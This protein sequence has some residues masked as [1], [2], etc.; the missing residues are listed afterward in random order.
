MRHTWAPPAGF[1]SYKGNTKGIQGA[2]RKN[3]RKKAWI[4]WN[5][6]FCLNIKT[7]TDGARTFLLPGVNGHPENEEKRDS[8]PPGSPRLLGESTQFISFPTVYYILLFH[9]YIVCIPFAF[10]LHSYLDFYLYFICIF[11]CMSVAF[12]LNFYVYLK[13]SSASRRRIEN[14]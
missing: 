5:F 3:Q 2:E 6:I 12:Y 7:V 4:F 13:I 11:I 10:Y 1:S 9:L 14:I 8:P